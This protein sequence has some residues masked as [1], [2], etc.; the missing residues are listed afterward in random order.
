MHVTNHWHRW[1]IAPALVVLVALAAC[2]ETPT[3]NSGL[4]GLS[5]LASHQ[6][7][8]GG[9]VDLL[10][11]QDI[12]VGDVTVT[13]D[14]TDLTVQIT[15]TGDWCVN[16]MH[17]DAADTEDGI[18][19]NRR[20]N[21][22][23]GQFQINETLSCETDFSR[24]L[25]L[26]ADDNGDDHIVVAVHTVVDEVVSFPGGQVLASDQGVKK[27]GDPVN[28]NRSNPSAALTK[29]YDHSSRTGEFFSLGFK[30][31]GS[32]GFLAE[33]GS[34]EVELACSIQDESGADFRVW[35]VTT[36]TSYPEETADVYAWDEAAQDWKFMG[37]AD[38]STQNLID[39]HTVSDFDLANAGLA[40]TTRLRIVDTT[41]PAPHNGNADAFDVDG[42]EALNGCTV[43]SETA[44]ADGTRFLDR[45]NWATYIEYGVTALD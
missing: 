16:E 13:D 30:E 28:A 9:N 7:S 20:G 17:L 10:A 11:G 31:D 21:P 22:V 26:P 42:I 43:Q 5:V 25:A 39:A 27:N 29:D 4:E 18:P 19:Q 33:G 37:T 6:I 45:G 35:E 1:L 38:N 8:S 2:D 44:W 32:G 3:Q 34:L 41:D 15:T 14:G 36:S 23:P 40:S 24:T 12:D